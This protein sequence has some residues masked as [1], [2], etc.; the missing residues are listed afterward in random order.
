MKGLRS[1]DSAITDVAPAHV[2]MAAAGSASE[3]YRRPKMA[4]RGASELTQADRHTAHLRKKRQLKA[5]KKTADTRLR[6]MAKFDE[7]ARRKVEKAKVVETLKSSKNVTILP[8][9]KGRGGAKGGR[10]KHDL[11]N[12]LAKPSKA[13]KTAKPLKK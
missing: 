10:W 6:V 7:G 1:L 3:A 13:A 8:G 5:A 11:A 2:P 4:P 9:Q 12:T